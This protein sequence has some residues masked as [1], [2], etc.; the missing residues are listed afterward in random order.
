[1]SSN[2]PTKDIRF[3]KSQKLKNKKIILGITGSIA[4]VQVIKLSRE[5]IR[6]GAEV[7]AVM[8][9]EAEDIITPESVEFATGNEVI[10]ELTGKVEHV[11]LAGERSDKA[12]LLLVYPSTANTISKIANGIDDTPVTTFATTAFPHIPIMIAPAMHESMYDHQILQENIEKLK[13]SGV[14]FVDPLLKEGKAKAITKEKLTYRVIKRLYKKDLK[15]NNVLVT[16]GPT[17]EYLDPIRFI[18]SD[19][20]GKTGK[21]I[22]EEADLRG[23]NVDLIRGK[24]SKKP[25]NNQINQ[26]EVETT[27]EML[28]EVKRKLKNKEIDFCILTA[29]VA[30]FKPEKSGRKIKSGKELNLKLKQTPK[31]L[32][33]IKKYDKS[34]NVIGFKAEHGISK[35]KLLSEAKNKLDQADLIV[36]NDVSDHG[37]GT[38]KNEVYFV[39]K[40]ATKHVP[41]K[42]KEKIA[43]DL[44]NYLNENL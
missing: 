13:N 12:D 10:T 40:E 20:S 42:T 19:S 27:E 23:A 32:K 4:A 38:D 25:K 28:N 30:D 5:L 15:G 39:T 17:R 2:H 21:S 16:S 35:E 31:I 11:E 44:W 1:M 41:L 6:H 26:I 14:E 8:T 24:G 3:N 9:P 36:A 22:A 34:T 7:K 33:K 37:F 18:T 43:K 29:A